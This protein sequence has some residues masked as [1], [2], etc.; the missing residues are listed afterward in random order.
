MMGNTHTHTSSE[1]PSLLI[2][3]QR[4]TQAG[5]V[6]PAQTRHIKESSPGFSIETPFSG[7]DTARHSGG[8]AGRPKKRTGGPNNQ[9]LADD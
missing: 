8:R 9:A 3:Q 1:E 2:P 5:P 7:G 4:F 6:S